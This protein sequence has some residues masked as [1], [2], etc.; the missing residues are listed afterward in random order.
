MSYYKP[1]TER[2]VSFEAFCFLQYCQERGIE[3]TDHTWPSTKKPISSPGWVSF[4]ETKHFLLSI[5]NLCLIR[6]EQE[7]RL[8][9]HVIVNLHSCHSPNW[10]LF[11][12]QK[13][14]TN[15][16]QPQGQS[17]AGAH[18]ARG[19]WSRG[20]DCGSTG[21]GDRAA[22]P[23]GQGTGLRGCRGL[24]MSSEPEERVPAPRG[25]SVPAWAFICCLGEFSA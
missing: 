14:P 16:Q 9:N 2:G 5:M 18:R 12:A 17:C 8:F 1:S 19:G 23:P 21:A 10:A 11:V 24:T 3:R 15:T 7:K 22:A 4:R 13:H 20:Q 25:A 6:R